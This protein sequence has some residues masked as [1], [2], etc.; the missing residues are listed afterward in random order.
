MTASGTGGVGGRKRSSSRESTCTGRCLADLMPMVCCR[1]SASSEL[2]LRDPLGGPTA[3]FAL[4]QVSRSAS[5]VE[6]PAGHRSACRV[7]VRSPRT[8]RGDGPQTPPAPK[9]EHRFVAGSAGTLCAPN[10][11][12][13]YM[14]VVRAVADRA[15]SP[16]V[17]QGVSAKSRQRCSLPASARF[18][19][20][21]PT[22][23]GGCPLDFLRAANFEPYS[24]GP[25]KQWSSRPRMPFAWRTRRIESK[26]SRS[27][28][29]RRV[30]TSTV[31]RAA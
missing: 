31:H 18:P 3:A 30:G 26:H 15:R 1:L 4:H 11:A 7:P 22:G 24:G 2:A 19:S 13:A 12:A 8:S 25:M 27:T 5:T 9:P 14:R 16:R 23:C 29:R 17:G 20:M 28:T 6:A 21:P 10:C